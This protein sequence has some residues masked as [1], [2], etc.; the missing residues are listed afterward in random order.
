MKPKAIPVM[1]SPVRTADIEQPGEEA[2]H[3][4]MAGQGEQSKNPS[5]LVRVNRAN[6]LVRPVRV[7]RLKSHS[8]PWAC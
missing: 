7:N 2:G 5:R 8:E 4:V 3:Q 6:R 1:N